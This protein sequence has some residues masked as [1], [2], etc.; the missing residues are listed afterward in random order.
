M[1]AYFRYKYGGPEVLQLE[2]LEKPNVG[3]D[4]YWFK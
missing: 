2:E 1:K 3:T 4:E